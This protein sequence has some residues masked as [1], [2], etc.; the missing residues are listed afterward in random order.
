MTILTVQQE[1]KDCIEYETKCFIERNFEKWAD[2][3]A[4]K[5]Y[6]SIL[7]ARPAFAEEIRGWDKISRYMKGLLSAGTTELESDV[8]KTKYVFQIGSDMAFVT[9]EE[10]G[11]SSSRVLEKTDGSWKISHVGVVYTSQYKGSGMYIDSW[12]DRYLK[13]EQTGIFQK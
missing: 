8:E 9:F 13:L 1:I 10:N 5:D 2:C 4:Q 6:A 7:E 3:W 11:N 12:D